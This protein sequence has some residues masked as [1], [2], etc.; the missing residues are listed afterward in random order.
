MTQEQA[1]ARLD[2]AEAQYQATLAKVKRARPSAA[3]RAAH[4][5]SQRELHDARRVVRA[6]RPMGISIQED[7]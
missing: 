3:D 1:M 2:A 6:G 4:V 5:A 7:N